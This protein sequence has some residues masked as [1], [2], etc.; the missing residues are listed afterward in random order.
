MP[1]GKR[2]SLSDNEVAPLTPDVLV[3]LCFTFYGGAPHFLCLGPCVQEVYSKR[4]SETHSKTLENKLCTV[5]CFPPRSAVLLTKPGA[6]AQ[7]TGIEGLLPDTFLTLFLRWR[8][9]FVLI[10]L[11]GPVRALGN[12]FQQS[13]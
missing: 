2:V 1:Q 10:V 8:F 3:A 7:I 9:P 6:S 13:H 11:P 12:S 4:A 5:V